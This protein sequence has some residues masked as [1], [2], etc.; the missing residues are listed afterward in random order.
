MCLKILRM[1]SIGTTSIMRRE[2][3][4]EYL[5]PPQLCPTLILMVALRTG[6]FANKDI[7]FGLIVVQKSKKD[8]FLFENEIVFIGWIKKNQEIIVAWPKTLQ[9]WTSK[10]SNTHI[11]CWYQYGFSTHHKLWMH[12]A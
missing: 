5:S 11:A 3:V 2:I 6:T 4:S 10:L 7:I 9:A 8:I 1:I 12:V